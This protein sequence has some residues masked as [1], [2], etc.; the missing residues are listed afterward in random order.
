MKN[1]SPKHQMMSSNFTEIL[2]ICFFKFLKLTHLRVQT[3]IY[4]TQYQ[5]QIISRTDISWTQ[6]QV[7]FTVNTHTQ[8][9]KNHTI[10]H[11][12]NTAYSISNTSE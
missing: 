2:H 8:I 9:E 5:K 11:V 1:I 10:T 3:I 7:H 4:Y 6:L 12:N